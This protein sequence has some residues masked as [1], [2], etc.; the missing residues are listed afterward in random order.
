VKLSPGGFPPHDIREDDPQPLYAHIGAE[1]EPLGLAY[2]HIQQPIT[3]WGMPPLPYDCIAHFRQYY[4]GTLFAGGAFDAQSAEE[5]LAHRGADAV[6]FGRAFLANPDLPERF[7][8]NAPLN[9][10]Q[11]ATFYSPGPKGYT[12]Y[13]PL[14]IS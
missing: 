2:V 8:R 9:E 11:V 1:L 12:D 6:F 3:N 7:R 13:P 10:P 14:A 5:A 4:G